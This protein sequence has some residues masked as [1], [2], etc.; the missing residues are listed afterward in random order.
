MNRIQT[1]RDRFVPIAIF[2]APGIVTIVEHLRDMDDA[3]C[4]SIIIQIQ[5]AQSNIIPGMAWHGMA[6]HCIMYGMAYTVGGQKTFPSSRKI[7]SIV[8][9]WYWLQC[10]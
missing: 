1:L 8:T 2:V 7:L 10:Y 5:I 9:M 4:W 3:F 6:W